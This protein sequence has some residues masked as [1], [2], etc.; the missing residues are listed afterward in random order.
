MENI[1]VSLKYVGTRYHGSQ[2]Q[3]NAPT[4]QGEFQKA[5]EKIITP[6]PD[7]KCC[8]RTD[9]GVHANMFCIS[10]CCESAP[11]DRK[12]IMALNSRLPHDIR[13]TD[14]KRV[15]QDFHA[16]YSCVSKTYEYL[17]FDGAVLDPFLFGRATHFYREIDAELMNGLASEFVGRHDFTAFSSP[18]KIKGGPVRTVSDFFVSRREDGII[19]FRV[20]ADGFLYN[21]VR[22]MVGTL[23]NAA[24]G[25]LDASD[26]RDALE[27]GKR[28]VYFVTAPAEGLYLDEVNYGEITGELSVNE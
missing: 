1:L 6:L 2:I 16:R 18:E 3:S 23:L 12:L 4:V 11:E 8:S 15:P 21:M 10:F 5:L 27:T 14:S 26:I 17:V 7:I 20:S 19:V 24:C 25:K 22:V 9:A 13:V 28:S